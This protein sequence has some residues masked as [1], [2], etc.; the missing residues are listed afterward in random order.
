M[1]KYGHDVDIYDKQ[2]RQQGGEKYR[3]TRPK[4]VIKRRQKGNKYGHF[5]GKTG[6]NMVTERELKGNKYGRI[7]GK[8]VV[9]SGDKTARKR[10]QTWTC[11]RQN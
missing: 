3:Q 9:K 4:L 11:R 1:R 10:R 2:N 5:G 8:T 6:A 7:G